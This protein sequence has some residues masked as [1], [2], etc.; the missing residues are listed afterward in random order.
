MLHERN[1]R[2]VPQRPDAIVPVHPH[3]TVGLDAAP[4]QIEVQRLHQRMRPITDGGDDGVGRNDGTIV[5]LDGGAGRRFGADAGQHLNAVDAEAAGRV[6][7]E[8]GREGRQDPVS[9]FDQV[10][11]NL[12]WAD[13]QIIFESV[14]YELPHLGHCLDPGEPGTHHYET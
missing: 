14:A 6:F 9:I 8:V 3:E 1:Q 13:V 11:A 12:V 4:M 7:G 2:R 5:Q 10:Y